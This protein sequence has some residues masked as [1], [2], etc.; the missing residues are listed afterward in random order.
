MHAIINISMSIINVNVIMHL[1]VSY[2]LACIDKS[3]YMR[4]CL[5]SSIIICMHALHVITLKHCGHGHDLSSDAQLTVINI[6]DIISA[7]MKHWRQN[8]FAKALLW[9]K[10]LIPIVLHTCACDMFHLLPSNPHFKSHH[11]LGVM[12]VTGTRLHNT[13]CTIAC[14]EPKDTTSFISGS[15][16][17][18]IKLYK[19]THT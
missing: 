3:T 9:A 8:A 4:A 10:L 1:P 5:A 11:L 7:L 2:K 16:V 6:V 17:S 15:R 13:L 18:Y 19:F 14:M 12:K